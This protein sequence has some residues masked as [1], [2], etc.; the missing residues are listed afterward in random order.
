M[1]VSSRKISAVRHLLAA[2]AL[3]M[4]LFP[5]VPAMYAQSAATGAIS[6]TVADANGALLPATV[7]TVTSVDTGAVRK[8]K[9]NGK[10]EFRV[11]E[12]EPGTYTV[13]FVA[14]GFET[15]QEDKVQVLVGQVSS[16]LPK[17]KVGS[18]SDKVEISADQGDLH[19]QSSEIS[20]T[21]DQNLIDNLPINGRRFSNFAC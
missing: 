20:T 11:P 12:L 19:L 4:A 1:L 15:S 21:I 9:T 8:V 13:T 14:D 16:L 5:F 10:G 17:L 7:V 6:G 2:A 3:V 18:V